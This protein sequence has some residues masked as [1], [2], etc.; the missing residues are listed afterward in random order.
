MPTT[1]GPA[2]LFA[3]DAAAVAAVTVAA[4]VAETTTVCIT[5]FGFDDEDPVSA[6]VGDNLDEAD[7]ELVTLPVAL[8][9]TRVVGAMGRV[10][11][12]GRP[13]ERAA[14]EEE[15]APAREANPTAA[16]E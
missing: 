10:V 11:P 16:G 1:A 13:V 7:N 8:A 15:M 5:T 12:V 4:D 6:A 14:A 2:A 9:L 3:V